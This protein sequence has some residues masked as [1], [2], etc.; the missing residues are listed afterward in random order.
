MQSA[1]VITFNRITIDTI[2][3]AFTTISSLLRSFISSLL[4]SFSSPPQLH[5]VSSAASS[6][7][8]VPSSDWRFQPGENFR[9]RERERETTKK[10]HSYLSNAYA[11][12]QETPLP[13]PN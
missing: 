10:E 2:Q 4:C 1:K 9:E 8:F 13:G 12:Q 11:C 3:P 7:L 6:R 5:L